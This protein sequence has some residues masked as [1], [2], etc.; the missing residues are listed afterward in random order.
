MDKISKLAKIDIFYLIF[1]YYFRSF[2]KMAS[3][4]CSKCVSE[5]KAANETACTYYNGSGCKFG[6]AC[7]K[8]HNKPVCI[9]FLNGNCTKVPCSFS[10]Q[11]PECTHSAAPAAVKVP[12]K[13]DS[14]CH[15][16]LRHSACAFVPADDDD[17]F[18]EV[19]EYAGLSGDVD[20]ENEMALVETL[21]IQVNNLE[22][23]QRHNQAA[24]TCAE[25]DKQA[26]ILLLK[27]LPEF[28]PLSAKRIMEMAHTLAR[29]KNCP[30]NQQH[31]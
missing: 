4:L 24:L 15:S 14:D 6:A 10:H 21:Q 9:F 17:S 1:H 27:T 2:H 20:V 25:D 8:K 19:D 31:Q 12:P 3:A 26:L 29:A 11:L 18:A 13:G 23:Q 5:A 30:G 16:N 7:K 28:A 22:E